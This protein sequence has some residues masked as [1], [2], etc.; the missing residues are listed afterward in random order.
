MQR[1][2]LTFDLPVPLIAQKIA[3]PK[4][5]ARLLVACRKD[6]SIAHRRFKDFPDYL[7]RGDVLVLNDT[8]VVPTRMWGALEGGGQVE[9]T[10]I[11]EIG[12]GLWESFVR[13]SGRLEKGKR[14]FFKRGLFTADMSGRA[15]RGAWRLKFNCGDKDLKDILDRFAEVNAPFYIRRNIKLSEYQNVYARR[16]G[17]TQCPT[18][19]LHF[20]RGMLDRIRDRG[21][22]VAFITLHI[23]GSVLPVTVDD[24]R[25]FRMYK[26][27][28]ELGAAAAETI[29]LA[30]RRGKKVMAVG[31]TVVRCLETA[32]AADEHISARRGWTSL[33]IKPPYRFKATD[34]FL[35]NLHL[36]ASSHLLLTT[37]FGGMSLILSAYRQAVAKRYRFLD[38]GDAMLVI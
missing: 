29:N 32:S 3:R 37:A 12:R 10:L 4:E 7:E 31:T 18:A 19:G 15:S 25:D 38:F 8:A 33:T 20:T 28:F 24:Y 5:R 1:R 21:V 9:V 16:R 17:S 6:G 26:E 27:Y 35:T 13:P 23:G 36:P 11:N 14:I 30:K 34:A 2:A 22:S